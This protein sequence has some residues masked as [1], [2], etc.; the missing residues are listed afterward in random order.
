MAKA[1]KADQ[2]LAWIETTSSKNSW[3]TFYYSTLNTLRPSA[4]FATGKEAV[5]KQYFKVS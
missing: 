5:A 3:N 2:L 4:D 1:G